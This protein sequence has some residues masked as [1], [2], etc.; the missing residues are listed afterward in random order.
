LSDVNWQ[1]TL[2]AAIEESKS[3]KAPLEIALYLNKKNKNGLYE[4][5]EMVQENAN[6]KHII[7]LQEDAPFILNELL[8]S[9][10]QQLTAALPNIPIGAGSD[11]F[12]TELNRSDLDRSIADFVSYPI[13]P[14]VHAF[15][16]TT[17]VENCEAPAYAV[18]TALHKFN[19]PVY[20]S[21]VTLKMRYS[22]AD[23]VTPLSDE[24][25]STPF[26]AVWTV[27][28][29][30]Y[31]IEAGA[32]S[33]TYFETTGKRGLMDD[34]SLTPFPVL[35]VF[36][37]VL[38]KK[39]TQVRKCSSSHPFV[40]DAMIIGNNKEEYLLLANYKNS[41]IDVVVNGT[42]GNAFTLHIGAMEVK[43]MKLE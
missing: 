9:T 40:C 2:A 5:I 15:D 19:K 4:F 11:H 3:I 16:D 37:H 21:P 29:L 26:C 35:E 23:N 17:M 39:I 33:I 10:Y 13:N 24:R 32:A 36:G 20:V 38:D 41:A 42:A 7:V 31:L 12:F 27:G 28:S 14:Q 25:Q 34:E 6:I 22:A 18:Q 43:K 1:Q 30:K 8:K